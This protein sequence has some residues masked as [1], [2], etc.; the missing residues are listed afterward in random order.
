MKKRRSGM[1]ILLVILLTSISAATAAEPL[2][3]FHAHLDGAQTAGITFAASDVYFDGYLLEIPI[4]ITPADPDTK[5]YEDVLGDYTTSDEIEA[6]Q[7]AG[8]MPLGA[9]CDILLLDENGQETGSLMTGTGETI[10][11]A[12]QMTFRFHF[13]PNEVPDTLHASVICG[14]METPGKTV[15]ELQV[16][17]C[18]VPE[19]K[20]LYT[21]SVP[22][23]GDALPAL[24]AVFIAQTEQ[25]TCA[26]A[27]FD[28]EALHNDWL[29]LSFGESESTLPAMS[30]T[31]YDQTH[32]KFYL[33]HAAQLSEIPTTLYIRDTQSLREYIIHLSDGSVTLIKNQ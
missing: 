13:F 5:V 27:F 10:G 7:K 32:G 3:A 1:F 14:V 8:F 24:E 16:F 31:G 19:Q 29:S 18:I 25:A 20:P 28:G 30:D 22:V 12:F 23:T 21:K 4:T 11:S 33:Y 17:D 2:T 26:Y 9:Y 15:G 6:I